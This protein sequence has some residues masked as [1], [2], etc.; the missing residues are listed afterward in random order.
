MY[1]VSGQRRFVDA[2][3]ASNFACSDNELLN[4]FFSEQNINSLQTSL[5]VIM[6][7]KYGYSISRQDDT[8]LV[9]IMRGVYNANDSTVS[10]S[11]VK[12]Q[13][14]YLN[15]RVLEVVIPQLRTNIRHY[16]G[17]IRD[18]T[19]PYTL[20]DRPQYTSQRGEFTLYN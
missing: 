8:E 13:V 12:K 6:K 7:E 1:D 4:T 10:Y 9:L 5:R 18:S 3:R 17:Y 2:V 19:R 15:M 16:L 11:C 14:E 20:L